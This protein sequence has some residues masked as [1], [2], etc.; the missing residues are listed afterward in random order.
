MVISRMV[1]GLSPTQVFESE[2]LHPVAAI[3]EDQFLDVRAHVVLPDA[4]Y[5][6]FVEV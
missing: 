3:T 2:F 6:I 5:T 1:G 4:F